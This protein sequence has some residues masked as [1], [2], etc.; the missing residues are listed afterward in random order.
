MNPRESSMKE[1]REATMVEEQE[2]M[3]MEMVMAYRGESQATSLVPIQGTTTNGKN[4][5]RTNTETIIKEM[6]ATQTSSKRNNEIQVR[7]KRFENSHECNLIDECFSDKED[8]MPEL[9]VRYIQR[10]MRCP[11]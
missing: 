6:R 5:R 11:S 1:K 7:N 10:T 9:V 8:N 3:E 4:T 2:S